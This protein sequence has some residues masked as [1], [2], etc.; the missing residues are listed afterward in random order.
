PIATATPTVT[1]TSTASPT[2]TATATQT[3]TSTATQTATATATA[4]KTATPTATA[5]ASATQTATATRTATSTATATATRTAIATATATPTA[6]ATETATPTATPT[7]VPQRL[8]VKP[9]PK[10]FGKAKVGS[11]K[12]ATLTLINAATKGPPITFAN[13]MAMIPANHPEF[14]SVATTCSAQLM[15]QKKCKLTVQFSPA[16][17][18]PKSSTVTIFDNA[19][20]A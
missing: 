18:G 6:T 1:A 10:N 16:S 12:R 17:V 20:N 4:T 13:P 5:T 14:S 3:A 11:T 7:Q 2:L 8:K 9:S 19:G 15:P